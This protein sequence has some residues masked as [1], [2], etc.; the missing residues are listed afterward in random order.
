MRTVRECVL[1][2]AHSFCNDHDLM[3]ALPVQ[4]MRLF[5]GLPVWT[6][7][8][9]PVDQHASRT[10]YIEKYDIKSS[11]EGANQPMVAAA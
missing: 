9:R 11:V 10:K 8:N 3:C 2:I 5:V 6:P 7:I 1:Y 4:A